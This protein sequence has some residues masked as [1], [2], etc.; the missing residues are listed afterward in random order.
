LGHI[1]FIGWGDELLDD[2]QLPQV[3]CSSPSR[4]SSLTPFL[5]LFFFATPEGKSDGLVGHQG[6]Y[7]LLTASVAVSLR[8][9]RDNRLPLYRILRK[10]KSRDETPKGNRRS[11]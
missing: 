7:Y 6:S 1:H 2:C 11:S 4:K 5:L 9:R 10:D 8:S 3:R